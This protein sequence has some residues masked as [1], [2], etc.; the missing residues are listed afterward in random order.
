[1]KTCGWRVALLYQAARFAKNDVIN[2]TLV[3]I[4]CYYNPKPWGRIIVLCSERV[5]NVRQFDKAGGRPNGSA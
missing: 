3:H 5:V 4:C 2:Y 1:M